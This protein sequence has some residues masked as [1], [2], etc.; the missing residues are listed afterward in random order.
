[1][2]DLIQDIIRRSIGE[3]TERIEP[4]LGNGECNDVYLVST[5]RAERILRMSNVPE[6]LDG[7]R[8]EEWCLQATANLIPGPQVLAVGKLDNYAF[9]IETKILG[10]MAFTVPNSAMAIWKKLGEYA[11][12]L[13]DV[14]V[15]GHGFYLAEGESGVFRYSWQEIVNWYSEYLFDDDLLVRLGVLSHKQAGIAQKIIEGMSE[16]E[17]SPRLNHGNL[18][19]KNAIIGQ[20]GIIYVIDWGTAEATQGPHLDIADVAT[21]SN[22]TVLN[23]FLDGYGI[24]DNEWARMQP[25]VDALVLRRALESVKWVHDRRHKMLA[26]YVQKARTHIERIVY[27]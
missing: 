26:N 19:L 2:R 11:H 18:A 5:N 9:M 3:I 14:A 25:T 7:Y 21:W 24:S 17:F 27:G 8:K 13:K 12:R 1:M 10:T 20:E 6:S 23:S 15:E 16:W 4:I 22:G